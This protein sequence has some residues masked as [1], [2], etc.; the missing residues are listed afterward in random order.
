M[1]FIQSR[2]LVCAKKQF[3]IANPPAHTHARASEHNS[4]ER[5]G[6]SRTYSKH[7]TLRL[8]TVVH[9]VRFLP[10]PPSDFSRPGPFP[11]NSTFASLLDVETFVGSRVE[12]PEIGEDE[13]ESG[14]F[15]M[16]DPSFQRSVHPIRSARLAASMATRG[17]SNV[18]RFFSRGWEKA[19]PTSV[20]PTRRPPRARTGSFGRIR[21]D[22]ARSRELRLFIAN[23]SASRLRFRPLRVRCARTR[24]KFI[25]ILQNRVS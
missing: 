16:I 14:R 5:E 10:R 13:R 7:S 19:D 11:P 4:K 21:S 15:F 1:R 2:F 23:P 25:A 6:H 20:P 12:A 24:R 8:T 9:K 18:S 17:E 22:R 3:K